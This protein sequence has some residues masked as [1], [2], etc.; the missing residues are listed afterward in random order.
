MNENNSNIENNL[1]K[2]SKIVHDAHDL[3]KL[4][5]NLHEIATELFKVKNFYIALLNKDL[6]LLT[7]PYYHDIK[8]QAPKEKF[9]EGKGL[10]HYTI[11]KGQGLIFNKEDYQKLAQQNVIQILG[12]T[13][14]SWLGVPLK[15]YNKSIIGLIVI[16]SYREEILFDKHD[17]K[18]YVHL[19]STIT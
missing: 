9:S 13:P 17:T 5:K 2:I 7:Y 1:Y 14:Y 6:D 19:Y 8:D 4:F 12:S 11:K 18:M 16:Q 3:N 15:D 10:T